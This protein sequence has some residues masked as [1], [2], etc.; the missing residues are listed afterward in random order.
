MLFD[1]FQVGLAFRQS[2]APASA[3]A[4]ASTSVSASASA[5]MFSHQAWTPPRLQVLLGAEKITFTISAVNLTFG[6]QL[7]LDSYL[8][9]LYSNTTV[10][11]I[12]VKTM[13]LKLWSPGSV[14]NQPCGEGGCLGRYHRLRLWL[15]IS[16][17]SHASEGV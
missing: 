7:L 5:A 16:T 2:L 10:V 9:H 17:C 6:I 3:S 15:R 1:G 14:S 13:G 8:S 4:S 11:G 12:R